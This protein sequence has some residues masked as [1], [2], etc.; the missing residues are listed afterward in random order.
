MINQDIN[1]RAKKGDVVLCACP[2]NQSCTSMIVNVETR[3]S[4]GLGYRHIV[5]I[6]QRIDCIYIY[7]S[8]DEN[9]CYAFS[10]EIVDILDHLP[11]K[12]S[13]KNNES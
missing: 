3:K 9:R 11:T 1:R 7:D 5:E 8:E 6:K 4:P 12:T 10:N 2:S 13:K